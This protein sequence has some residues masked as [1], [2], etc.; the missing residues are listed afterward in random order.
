MDQRSAM[1]QRSAM[2]LARQA[3]VAPTRSGPV[4][5]R[6]AVPGDLA[7]A[8]RMHGRCSAGSLLRRYLRGGR[9][10][11]LG[12]LDQLL[13]QPLVI[14]A[15]NQAGDMVA[16]AAVTQ[17]CALAGQAPEAHTTVQLGILVEDGWQRLGIGRL[18]AG[19][20]A[21]SAK[22]LGRRELVADVMAVDLPLRRILD[23]IG[24][25]RSM[26]HG[27]GWRLR[28]RLEPSAV[29]HLGSLGAMTPHG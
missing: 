11:A 3:W 12:T 6:G 2:G 24:P 7:A 16:L 23:D 28:T 18:L 27:L 5:V 4:R 14:V 29:R 8:A 21:A 25:T 20:L 1:E 13:H 17:A 10:P 15:A 9:A 19:H 22:V 26:R